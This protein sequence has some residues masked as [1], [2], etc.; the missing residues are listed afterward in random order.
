MYTQYSVSDSYGLHW[1]RQGITPVK[2]RKWGRSDAMT[3]SCFKMIRIMQ[4]CRM[5]NADWTLVSLC[6]ALC[7]TSAYTF[8]KRNA[9]SVGADSRY[10]RPKQNMIPM[11]PK[12]G[13]VEAQYG[14]NQCKGVCGRLTWASSIAFNPALSSWRVHAGA[15]ASGTAPCACTSD[16]F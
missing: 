11:R 15:P 8:A 5:V 1:I 12:K 6:T 14:V 7:T 9:D 10:L 4:L 3:A 13:D 16:C 2:S